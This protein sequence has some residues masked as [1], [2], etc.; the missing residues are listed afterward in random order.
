MAGRSRDHLIAGEWAEGGGASFESRDPATGDLVWSGRE[1]TTQQVADGVSAARRAFRAWSDEPVEKRI[2]HLRAFEAKLR[3]ERDQLAEAISLETGKP[4]WESRG[5]ADVMVAKVGVSIDAWRERRAEAQRPVSGARGVVRFRPHGVVA[6][7]GPFNLPG[8]LPNGHIVPALLAGNTVVFKPSEKTPAVGQLTAELWQGSGLPDGVANLV[9]GGAQA[10]A[11]LAGLEDIDGL[12]FTG[13]FRV[14]CALSRTLADRPHKILALEMGGNNPLLVYRASDVNAAA[15]LAVVSAF[16]TAGQRCTCARRLVLVDGEEADQLLPR[17]VERTKQIRVGRW[18]DRPE[19][20]CGPLI[21]KA[22]AAAVLEM[23]RKLLMQG[24]QPLVEAGAIEDGSALVSPGIIDMTGVQD[25]EDE[26]CF[27]P[28]LQVIRVKDFDAA[29][30][31]ANRTSYGLAASLLSDDESCYQKF[32]NRIRAGVINW[33]RPTTGASGL[34][35]F[36][37]VGK[38]GNHRSSGYYAADYCSYPVASLEAEK[39]EM[40]EKMMPGLG[41]RKV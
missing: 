35:P 30:E 7:L 17:L 6:V 40:P 19:P 28:L 37:G 31:E 34:L 22:A 15:Y 29:I 38:S 21:D 20:F 23:Q 8:H 18:T 36:G 13:S 2:E 5:E 11:A 12:M 32:C 1:A 25:R 4:L 39:V 26:E 27:G 3:S 10:G 33:N 14:G 24:G 41:G 9:Q 16:I